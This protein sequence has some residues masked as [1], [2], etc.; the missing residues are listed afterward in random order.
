LDVELRSLAASLV[1]PEPADGTV[2]AVMA[3]LDGVQVPAAPNW[4]RRAGATADAVRGR[5]RNRWR[6]VCVAL[7]A[8]LLVLLAV[9]PAGA[10][11][12]EWLGFGAVVIEQQQPARTAESTATPA[13]SNST[14]DSPPGRELSLDQALAESSF[15]IGVPAA[16]GVPDRVTA[17]TDGRLVSMQWMASGVR[18]DQID[19]A[20]SPYLFKKISDD[21]EFAVVDG[22]QAL[23][24]ARP[25]PIMVLNPDGSERV[26]SARQSGP[27]LVWQDGDVTLRLEG[28]ADSPAAVAIAESLPN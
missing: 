5:L 12:R 3:R 7:A 16:L 28:V 26:E 15:P 11:V 27:A 8:M 23:W 10:K 14:A 19:G 4:W 20:L 17:S 22:R 18:L 21:V 25:H 6:T 24:L 1:I 2:Q 9:T 13:L